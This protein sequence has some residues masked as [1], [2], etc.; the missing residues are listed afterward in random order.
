MTQNKSKWILD[1]VHSSVEF[2]VKHM[3]VAWV[4]GR[5]TSATAEAEFS[6]E[7]LEEG[8]VQGEIKTESINTFEESRD[9]HLKSADFFDVENYPEIKFQSSEI[10]KI[11]DDEY[12]IKGDL[13]IRDISKPTVLKTTFFGAREIPGG[14]GKDP[15]VRSGFSAKTTINR[16]DFKVSWDAPA[17]EGVSTV[18][19]E[20]EI[21]L[22]IEMIKQ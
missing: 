14:E 13:T 22:Q 9:R 5:F 3:G 15:V 20:V 8:S 11:K 7:N 18:A 4:K 16:H 10:N 1:P 17:G 6:P 12:E 2:N 21:I 19:G